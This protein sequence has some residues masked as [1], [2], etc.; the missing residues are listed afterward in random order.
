MNIVTDPTA[1]EAGFMFKQEYG[2][3]NFLKSSLFGGTGLID[4]KYAIN[5][6]VVRKIGDGHIDK[7]WTDAWAYYFGASYNISENQRIELY[8][9][10]APQRHGQ[11][12]YKQ[13]IAAYD[14]AYAKAL[15][16]Q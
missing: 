13:N 5:A 11:N 15:T 9:V 4:G 6:G 12:L 8:A 7:T 16:N 2:S 10:G 1:S 14:S 3:G